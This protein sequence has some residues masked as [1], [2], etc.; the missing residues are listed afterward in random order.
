MRL[1]LKFCMISE[2]ILIHE[3]RINTIPTRSIKGK[4]GQ[5]SR[6]IIEKTKEPIPATNALL[7]V[8]F[9]QNNPN[10]KITTIPGVK[11]PVNSWIN[12]NACEKFP[13]RGF[14]IIIA[15][16]I[17]VSPATR[18]IVTSLLSSTLVFI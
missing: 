16:T 18:P 13:S 4:S 17:E 6:K 14:A 5:Y 3:K 12:W 15:M 11:N 9:F 8:A 2:I 7:A 1:K 10:R